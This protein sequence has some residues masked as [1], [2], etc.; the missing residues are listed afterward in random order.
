[1]NQFSLKRESSVIFVQPKDPEIQK[2]IVWSDNIVDEIIKT[3]HN[4]TMQGHLDPSNML[5][6]LRNRFSL[7]PKV[8]S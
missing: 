5:K 1:M 6:D 8:Q 2:I 7:A 4:K 3:L